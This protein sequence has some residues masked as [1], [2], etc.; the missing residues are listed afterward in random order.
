MPM[1]DVILEANF[2]NHLS[3]WTCHLCHQQFVR[4]NQY[5]SCRDKQ[6]TD[7][8]KN[9]P[10]E[11]LELFDHLVITFQQLGNVSYHATKSMIAFSVKTRIAYITRVGKNFI[12]VSFMFNRPFNDN[13]CFYRIGQVPGTEQYNHYFRMMYN[14]DINDEVKHYMQLAIDENEKQYHER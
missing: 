14:D 9:R 1:V 13:L 11:V 10:K 8:F 2:H 7:F 4:D 3:M 12:D 5:H 6:I